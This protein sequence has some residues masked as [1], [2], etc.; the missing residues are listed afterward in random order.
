MRDPKE[1]VW[2]LINQNI[3]VGVLLVDLDATVSWANSSACSVFGAREDA[4]AGLAY[5]ELFTEEDRALGAVETEFAIARSRGFSEDDRWHL[6]VD[7]SRFWASGLLTAVRSPGGEIVGFAKL[8]R[9]RTEVKEQIVTLRSE[10]AACREHVRRRA[11]A[12][13]EAAHEI[14]NA[15]SG[16]SALIG[17]LRQ[18]RLTPENAT[19]LI[20]IGERQ[21]NIA[22]RLTEDFMSAAATQHG[23]PDLNIERCVL[24]PILEE[25]VQLIGDTLGPRRLALLVPP[26]PVVS[27]LDRERLLQVLGNLL[28]NA[29]KFTPEH[30]HIWLKLTVEGSAAVIRVEDDGIG[31]EPE[32]LERIFDAFTQ[33]D[34]DAAAKRGIGMGLAIARATVSLMRGS[35]QATSDGPGRGATFTVRLPLAAV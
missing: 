34:A 30:G 14:R 25:T 31:I 4:F 18:G 23:A 16:M 6:R 1:Q 33:V 35:I 2:S 9:N 20:D 24:Q 26:A 21:L 17:A 28:R 3:G 32:M 19:Q 13:A 8:V 29:I 12:S 5:A 27:H 15:L 10:V 22:R 7:G 11:A